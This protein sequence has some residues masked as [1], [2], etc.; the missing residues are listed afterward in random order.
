[1]RSEYLKKSR[2]DVQCIQIDKISFKGTVKDCK[3]M[4][5]NNYLFKTMNN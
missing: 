4:K 3:A 1:M 5:F 2:V